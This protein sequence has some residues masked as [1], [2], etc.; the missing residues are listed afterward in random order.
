MIHLSNQKDKDA[1]L[2]L[3]F[4]DFWKVFDAVTIT[5]NSNNVTTMHNRSTPNK[6][7]IK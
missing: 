4:V 5:C 3:V 2:A 6:I 1:T 7:I